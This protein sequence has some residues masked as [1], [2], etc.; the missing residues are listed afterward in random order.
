MWSASNTAPRRRLGLETRARESEYSARARS[1]ERRSAAPITH[2]STEQ[3]SHIGPRASNSAARRYPAEDRMR[4]AWTHASPQ[5]VRRGRTTSPPH[6]RHPSVPPYRAGAWSRAL[7]SGG[8]AAATS[9]RL[10]AR[11]TRDPRQR[12]I[13]FC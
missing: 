13:Y 11:R 7:G 1:G 9:G 10:S 4:Y 8:P 12:G 2:V 3:I 5:K 6:H